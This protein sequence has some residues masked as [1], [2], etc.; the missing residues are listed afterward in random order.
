MLLTD[1][2]NQDV[3]LNIPTKRRTKKW[4][5]AVA[6]FYSSLAGS[7]YLA[8]PIEASLFR[9]YDGE[10]DLADFEYLT[11]QYG[12][13]SPSRL[14]HTPLIR[15]MLKILIGDYLER[16]EEILISSIDEKSLELKVNKEKELKLKMMLDELDKAV[17]N[18]K[19]LLEKG[20]TPETS[21]NQSKVSFSLAK[22]K[23]LEKVARA[24]SRLSIERASDNIMKYLMYISDCKTTL[25]QN[26]EDYLITAASFVKI[27]ANVK[28]EDPKLNRVHPTKVFYDRDGDANWLSE[29]DW[30][31]VHYSMP[32]SQVVLK[33]GHLMSREE[34]RSIE[35]HVLGSVRG[36]GPIYTEEFNG[37]VFLSDNP[38]STGLESGYT[39]TY[40]NAPIDVY[41]VQWKM[42][43]CVEMT[44]EKS[45]D[46][47]NE[48]ISKIREYDP[49]LKDEE[50]K[51]SETNIEKRY[52]QVLYSYYKIGADVF[53]PETDEGIAKW[54]PR[55]PADLCKVRLQYEGILPNGPSLVK[56]T[57]DLQDKYDIYNYLE[58][59]MIALSGNKG[60]VYPINLMPDGMVMT[61]VL[62]TMK[63][64]LMPIDGSKAD[65]GTT[66]T[67]SNFDATLSPSV[68][69]LRNAISSI[70][71]VA[72]RVTGVS[73]QRVAD[74][75]NSDLVG[76]TN[77]AIAQS[78]K[79]TEYLMTTMDS[80]KEQ[81]FTRL[82]NA[83]AWS[84]DS[85]ESV[86][87]SYINED[88]EHEALIITKDF[89]MSRYGVT[90]SNGGKERQKL[91]NL[92]SLVPELVKAQAIPAT[93][94]L[95]MFD[96][97][98][99]TQLRKEVEFASAK[100]EENQAKMGQQ[101]SEMQSKIEQTK[102]EMEQ[103]RLELDQKT[104][105]QRFQIDKEK[106][107][108]LKAQGEK[109]HELASQ[110]INLNNATNSK[111]LMLDQSKLLEDLDGN[112]SPADTSSIS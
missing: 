71:A 17:A 78:V 80:F 36:D 29:K 54:Q 107:A 51:E 70:E 95:S 6:N 50:N 4:G 109:E 55:D 110:E 73:R 43:T 106:I 112:T 58:E 28:G 49:A 103:K 21:F 57:K 9:I 41:H 12:V 45:K 99:F 56:L 72:E 16:G 105:D 65:S 27:E 39:G 92:Q 2:S 20:Q 60:I 68:Q 84:Y 86:V 44:R 83:A 74:I 14:T 46:R 108:I 93:V 11:K 42:N 90:L 82:L 15:P 26:F 13:E 18:Y 32:L 89:G 35:N 1:L 37:A 52:Y 100:A 87:K 31:A 22:L 64:G 67:F 75:S 91:Q 3:S 25:K 104:A 33:F 101:Q 77:Q 5:S 53:I 97:V 48:Y 30:V 94:L 63:L 79:A 24:D 85:V 61:D 98:N 81:I 23:D 8:K 69:Y 59:T 40:T 47:V 96:A 10:R 102:M 19:S 7:S 88:K 76:N 38:I 111:K 62:A 66:A 34:I